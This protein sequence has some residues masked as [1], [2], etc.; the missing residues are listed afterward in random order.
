MTRVG[1]GGWH[2]IFNYNPNK[3]AHSSDPVLPRQAWAQT[4]DFQ[5]A[6][7][8]AKSFLENLEQ[9]LNTLLR[10]R[11]AWQG[12]RFRPM[13]PDFPP[14]LQPVYGMP[15]PNP[16]D[17]VFQPPIIQPVYGMPD[18][19]N[20]PVIQ[21]VYGM[22][23]RPEPPVLQPVYGMPQRPNPPTLQ[24]IGSVGPVWV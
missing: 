4:S 19:P 12:P 9:R 8:E 20:P 1:G 23:A 15:Q 14:A 24:P 18:R 10:R 3:S 6:R 2:P 5:D 7:Q 17:P 21:P 16:E 11:G 13:P 22:P